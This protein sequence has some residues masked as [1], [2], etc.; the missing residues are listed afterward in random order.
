MVMSLKNSL[1]R[2]ALIWFKCGCDLNWLHFLFYFAEDQKTE[3]E[4]EPI[5]L[6]EIAGQLKTIGNDYFKKGDYAA[7]GKKY[8]KVRHIPY[9]AL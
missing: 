3:G 5:E 9:L 2:H 7:A 8:D 4:F 1:V 6:V